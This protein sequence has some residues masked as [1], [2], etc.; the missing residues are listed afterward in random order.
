VTSLASVHGTDYLHVIRFSPEDDRIL[1]STTSG[2]TV[3]ATSVWS[4]FADGSD[5]QLL[6]TGTG[7]GEFDWQP[8]PAGP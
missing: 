1:Y 5:A 4:A 8:L 7:W 6:V 3:G 2:T